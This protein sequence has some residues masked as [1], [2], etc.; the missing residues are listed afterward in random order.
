[1]GILTKAKEIADEKRKEEKEKL[2]QE[3][4]YRKKVKEEEDKKRSQIVEFLLGLSE[5]QVAI[6]PPTYGVGYAN[7][8]VLAILYINDVFIG[9]FRLVRN[10]YK[11]KPDDECA[12]ID[13][14]DTDLILCEGSNYKKLLATARVEYSMD[15]TFPM[16]NTFKDFEESLAKYLSKFLYT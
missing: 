14:C 1:M 7:E 15:D 8:N 4:A 13:R 16:E 3:A 10:Y 12:E 6:K 11:W 9:Q 2:E 5:G